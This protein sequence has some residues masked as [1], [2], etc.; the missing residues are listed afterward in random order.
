MLHFLTTIHSTMKEYKFKING[1]DYAVSINTVEDNM[2]SV[3]VNGTQYD[4]EISGTKVKQT[5][6][7]KIVQSAAIPAT[8]AH[9]AVAKTAAPSGA[10]TKIKSPL[11]GVILDLMVKEGDAVKVGQ[12]LMVIEAMKMENNIDSD[13]AGVVTEI[14]ARKGDSVLEGDVLI[15][16]G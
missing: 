12:H 1:N 6:T 14:K 10:G 15:T 5:K 7:P 13:V 11:P 2:A 9:P 4:V 16:I 8:D 3:S